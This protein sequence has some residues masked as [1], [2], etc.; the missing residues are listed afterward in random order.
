MVQLDQFDAKF[1]NSARSQQRLG[2][3]RTVTFLPEPERRPR[4][5]VLI[6]VDDHLIEPPDLFDGRLPASLQ[7][8][9]PRVVTQEDGTEAWLYEDQMFPNIGLS[10]VV[11]RP[12]EEWAYEPERFDEMR[13]GTWDPEARVKDMDIGGVYASVCFPSGIVGFGGQ[14]L[15]LSTNDPEL[16]NAIVRAV[17]DWH[18]DAWIGPR[19][20]RFIPVQIPHLLDVELAAAEVYRNAERGFK[21]V[22]F[23][24]APHKL[25]L[26]SLHTGYWD[27]FIGACEETETVICLHIGSSSDSPATA[28]DAPIDTVGVLFFAYAMFTAVDW[29]Y[30]FIPVKF[31]R[32]KI[33]MS[34][35]GIAWVPGLIDRLDHVARYQSIYGTW[36][37]IDLSPAEVLHRNFWQ[38]ALDDPSNLKLRDRIGVDRIL[39][40]VDYPHLDSTWPNSQQMFAE[41]LS[42][43]PADE[44]RLMA[45]ENASKLFRHDVPEEIVRNPDEFSSRTEPTKG[46]L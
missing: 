26:P 34:E 33:A 19:T 40:E 42:G 20:D 8:R 6:S 11:G 29:L 38:C 13:R 31:P 5:F 14:R 25:S 23:P 45:W 4:D 12:I 16:A 41:Q 3:D 17:N 35:G 43:V 21:A 1:A 36:E 22:T 32:I 37:G 2:G 44:V 7:E 10:A 24:E 28:P 39:L 15:Q 27:P 46:V 30:S 18:L 9:A